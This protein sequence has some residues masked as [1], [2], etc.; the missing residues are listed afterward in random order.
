M[1]GKP[2]GIEVDITDQREIENI[3]TLTSEGVR[4]ILVDSL[5]DLEFARELNFDKDDVTMVE[6]E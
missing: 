4:V 1:S 3:E 6:P 2:Y 5:D